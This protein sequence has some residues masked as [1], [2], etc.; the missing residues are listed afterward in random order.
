MFAVFSAIFYMGKAYVHLR[1]YM[2]VAMGTNNLEDYSSDKL[3]LQKGVPDLAF[4]WICG[5]QH[6][7]DLFKKQIIDKYITS[8]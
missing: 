5:T 1:T 2:R 8:I 6:K 7:T 3:L 4:L